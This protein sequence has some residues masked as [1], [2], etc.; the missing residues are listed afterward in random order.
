MTLTPGLSA[1]AR[2]AQEAMAAL[3]GG[4]VLSDVGADGGSSQTESPR[5]EN[6]AARLAALGIGPDG[7]LLRSPSQSS[8]PPSPSPIFLHRQPRQ[9]PASTI[10]AT[11]TSSAPGV[12]A[13]YFSSTDYGATALPLNYEILKP[14]LRF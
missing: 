12:R 14:L 9:A 8:A 10:S 4:T 6:L 2:Y 13:G 3:G 1:A 5:L 11:D 7:E